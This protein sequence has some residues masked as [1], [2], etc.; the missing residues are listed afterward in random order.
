MAVVDLVDLGRVVNDLGTELNGRKFAD[1]TLKPCGRDCFYRR[2]DVLYSRFTSAMEINCHG[3]LSHKRRSICQAIATERASSIIDSDRQKIP[4]HISGYSYQISVFDNLIQSQ[5]ISHPNWPSQ[6]LLIY[7]HRHFRGISQD[8]VS[9]IYEIYDQFL[10]TQKFLNT[11]SLKLRILKI[12]QN[13]QDELILHAR[14]IFFPSSP[15]PLPP[16]SSDVRR[17]DYS[18]S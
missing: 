12:L 15:P 8:I 6:T 17:Q 10:Q 5:W 2:S 18:P 14:F 11:R 9:G 7:D 13:F 3:E 4:F 1:K 16:T